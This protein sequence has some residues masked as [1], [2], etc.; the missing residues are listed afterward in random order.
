M[1]GILRNYYPRQ[2][3]HKNILRISEIISVAVPNFN[4]KKASG[5]KN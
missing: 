3:R 1:M 4:E 5:A 2:S